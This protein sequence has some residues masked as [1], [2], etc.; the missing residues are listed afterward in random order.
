MER[1]FALRPEVLRPPPPDTVVCR[2]EDVRAGD[3]DPAWTTREAKLQTR[4]G[5]GPCQGR[6]CGAALARLH[7]RE[8]PVPRSPLVPV[9]LSTLVP[10][11]EP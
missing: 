7:G 1:A 9:P 11:E 10:E 2:C 6:I 8:P 5:M 3:L 4:A